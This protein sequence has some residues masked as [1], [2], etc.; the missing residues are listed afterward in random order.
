MKS[1]KATN[2]SNNLHGKNP[3]VNSLGLDTFPILF[4]NIL[5]TGEA[6]EQ[7]YHMY[8]LN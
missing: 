8:H 4:Y 2:W 3:L 1:Q 5:V 6:R 7:V